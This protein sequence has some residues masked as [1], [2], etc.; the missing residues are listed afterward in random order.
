MYL[1]FGH[2]SLL[3]VLSTEP[4]VSVRITADY[5]IE[6][7]N[8]SVN[9]RNPILDVVWCAMDALKLLFE[10]FVFYLQMGQFQAVDLMYQGLY[11]IVKLQLAMGGICRKLNSFFH[12]QE[13]KLS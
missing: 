5:D 10:V 13:G 11:M 8:I 1:F 12:I 7:L 4:D 3:H 2:Q 9:K 6:Q